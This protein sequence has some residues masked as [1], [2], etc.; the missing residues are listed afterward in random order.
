MGYLTNAGGTLLA[1]TEGTAQEIADRIRE[2]VDNGWADEFSADVRGQEI[3][4]SV[5][6]KIFYKDDDDSLEAFVAIAPLIESGNI[7]CHGEE[8]EDIWRIVFADGAAFV[9]RMDWTGERTLL[10]EQLRKDAEA[11]AATQQA[12]AAHQQ[13]LA[14]EAKDL[15]MTV[16]DMLEGIK[17]TTERR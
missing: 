15:G 2:S 13:T 6:G 8:S 1:K 14:A 9:E 12:I 11:A 10:S 16:E 7:E 17:R 4:L 5:Y 3:D